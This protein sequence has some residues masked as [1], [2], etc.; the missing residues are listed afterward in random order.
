MTDAGEILKSGALEKLADL[1]HKLAGP[2]SEEV[3][4][5]LGDKVRAYRY[6]NWTQTV[7]KTERLLRDAGLPANAVPPRLFLPIME[8]CSVE[9]NETLQDMWAGLLASASQGAD[10]VSPSFVETLKHLT[11]DEARDFQGI[12]EGKS[13]PA[14]RTTMPGPI[15]PFEVTSETFE[16]LGL[17]RRQFHLRNIPAAV[18]FGEPD[19][20]DRDPE[21][22]CGFELTKFAAEFMRACQGPSGKTG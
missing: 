7:Q 14:W 22:V 18:E 1:V 19:G 20:P 6:R 21:I 17:V 5:M 9:D 11:P 13:R 16:R 3:G 12:Y 10:A 2:M 4:L 15:Y 8:G